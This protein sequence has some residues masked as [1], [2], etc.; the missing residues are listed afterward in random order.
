L[1]TRKSV[2]NRFN[3]SL[4]LSLS[5][6]FVRSFIIIAPTW[7]SARC[8]CCCWDCYCCG[9]CGCYCGCGCCC[10]WCSLDWSLVQLLL[11]LF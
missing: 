6:S 7:W 2:A 5:L 8:C 3:C 10:S 11:L 4:P 1:A 9:W